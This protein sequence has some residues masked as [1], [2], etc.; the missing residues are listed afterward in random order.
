MVI[1][2]RQVLF[3]GAIVLYLHYPPVSQVTREIKISWIEEEKIFH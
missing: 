3:W 1:R 2:R